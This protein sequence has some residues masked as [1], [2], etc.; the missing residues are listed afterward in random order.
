MRGAIL[1]GA[2]EKRS[3][4]GSSGSAKQREGTHDGLHE[5]RNAPVKVA[6][7]EEEAQEGVGRGERR[8]DAVLGVARRVA[9]DLGELEEERRLWKSAGCRAWVS[10]PHRR[11]RE[12][13]GTRDARR[14]RGGFEEEQAADHAHEGR[15]ARFWVVLA[16]EEDEGERDL[17]CR[18]CKRASVV[19]ER[20][21]SAAGG[22][23]EDAP[24][25]PCG[26][27]RTALHQVARR[28]MSPLL[29]CT[30]ETATRREAARASAGRGGGAEGE[31]GRRASKRERKSSRASWAALRPR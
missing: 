25:A 24:V 21:A 20:G 9:Q 19:N 5:V 17:V 6:L 30:A 13:G 27:R 28:L 4:R 31:E 26:G 16:A 22:E 10:E 14:S 18:T 29:A 12:A 2:K 8:C 3:V 1:R 7:L 15:P 23:D 11:E